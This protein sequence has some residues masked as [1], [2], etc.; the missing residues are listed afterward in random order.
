[1]CALFR[2]AQ[3]EAGASSDHLFLELDVVLDRLDHIEGARD[4]ADQRDHV[5]AETSL[6]RRVLVELVEHDLGHAGLLEFNHDAHALAIRLVPQVR[7]L[8][9]LLLT[10]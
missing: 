9:E 1:M 2:L 8:G 6:Q 4:T 5:Y 3:L 10:R 7:Y